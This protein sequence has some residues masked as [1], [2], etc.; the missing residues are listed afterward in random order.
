MLL[1][2]VAGACSSGKPSAAPRTTESSTAPAP[3]TTT[4][5]SSTTSTTVRTSS[6]S[7]TRTTLATVSIG[8]GD[9]F[10]SGV[11]QGPAGPVDGATVHIERV[12]GAGVATADV[13]T[14]G[15]GAWRMDSVLGGAYRVR[16]F[17]APDLGQSEVEVFFLAAADRKVVNLQLGPTGG[18]PQIFAVVNPNPPRVSQPAIVT[19]QIGTSQVDAQGR[20]GIIPQVGTVLQLSVGAGMTLEST[21]Q[22]ATDAT[23]SASWRVR[24]LIPGPSS[25]SVTVGSS[26]TAPVNLP[27]CTAVTSTPAA[28]TTTLAR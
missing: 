21:P 3:T 16:A 23:G 15:G 13:T 12:V 24:C 4:P 1:V 6:T 17:K 5:T 26:G 18:G 2:L 11:V 7:T 14:A 20:P 9:A 28:T 22:V 10:L 25:V 8:P 19:V 27:P